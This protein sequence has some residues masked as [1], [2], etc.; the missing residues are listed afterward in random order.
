[1]ASPTVRKA[2]EGD[3]VAPSDRIRTIETKLLTFLRDQPWNSRWMLRRPQLIKHTEATVALLAEVRFWL[4]DPDRGPSPALGELDDRLAVL[5]HAFQHDGNLT[6]AI[7]P[8]WMEEIEGSLTRI[9]LLL[10]GND[11]HYLY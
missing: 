8:E 11:T 5:E 4:N 1:M 6:T 2:T 3:A 7:R 9:L 10:H